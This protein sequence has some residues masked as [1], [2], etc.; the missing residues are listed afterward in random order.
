M[1]LGY[2]K[3][4]SGSSKSAVSRRTD[5]ILRQR[6][7]IFVATMDK[8]EQQVQRTEINLSPKSNYSDD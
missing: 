1:I 6:R 7:L 2:E 5:A 3:T 4:V 8:M